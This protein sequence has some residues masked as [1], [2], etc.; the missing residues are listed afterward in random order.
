VT[1]VPRRKGTA[2]ETDVVGWFHRAGERQVERNALHGSR[3]IGDLSGLPGLVV[4]VK[5]VG[6]GKPM[7]LSG[8]LNDLDAMRTNQHRRHAHIP[9]IE[10]P[11][12][13]LIVRRTGYPD[14]GDWYAVQRLGDWWNVFSET[15]LT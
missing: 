9:G 10:R 11:E 1:N 5:F 7:D 3:D 13:L 2:A 15:F 6:R 8:W 12:G 4:S 14:P